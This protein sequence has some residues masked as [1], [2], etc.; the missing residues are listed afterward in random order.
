MS[1]Q[2]A[3]AHCWGLYGHRRT[4]PDVPLP[5]LV[6]QLV[7]PGV[8]GVPRQHHGIAA[9]H[10]QRCIYLQQANSRAT[11][12]AAATG[13]RVGHPGP[14]TQLPTSTNKPA[15]ARLQRGGLLPCYHLG[16]ETVYLEPSRAHRNGAVPGHK[17]SHNPRVRSQHRTPRTA[18]NLRG[19]CAPSLALPGSHPTRLCSSGQHACPCPHTSCARESTHSVTAEASH[20]TN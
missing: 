10:A 8:V 3:N 4:A 6:A 13:S 7:S 9:G 5:L 1:P 17:K 15:N 2:I 20:P 14:G 19:C 18:G 12:A 11:L 16:W